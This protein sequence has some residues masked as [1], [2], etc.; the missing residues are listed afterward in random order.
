M[1]DFFYLSPSISHVFISP[2]LMTKSLPSHI[3]SNLSI[4]LLGTLPRAV[5]PCLRVVK[6]CPPK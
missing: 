3:W 1:R 2:I 5:S 6:P 4:S